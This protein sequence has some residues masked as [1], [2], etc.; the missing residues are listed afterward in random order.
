MEKMKWVDAFLRIERSIV[1]FV[2]RNIIVFIIG[3]LFGLY[4]G[5]QIYQ[6]QIYTV[7]KVGGFVYNN[8]VYN[9]VIRK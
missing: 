4:I 2:N 9:V 6:Y 7:I 5:Y 8:K 1:A 3:I